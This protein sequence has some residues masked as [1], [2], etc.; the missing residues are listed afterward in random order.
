MKSENSCKNSP[1]TPDT[2]YCKYYS[3]NYPTR[4][5]K[6]DIGGYDFFVKFVDPRI[7]FAQ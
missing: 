3:K 4:F 5:W 7:I 1:I 2:G 6:D